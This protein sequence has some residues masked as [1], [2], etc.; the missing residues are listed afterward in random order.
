[1][2]EENVTRPVGDDPHEPSQL[3]KR[4][5]TGSLDQIDNRTSSHNMSQGLH[6]Q[7]VQNIDPQ[8][9][10]QL[11]GCLLAGLDDQE[12]SS[13]LSKPITNA[14][15]EGNWAYSATDLLAIRNIFGEQ[16]Y[17]AV[18]NSPKRMEEK[19]QKN[20]GEVIECVRMNFSRR[21]LED[22][23]IWLDVGFANGIAR[24]LFPEA[25]EG[26]T[27]LFNSHPPGS[28]RASDVMIPERLLGAT[29][30]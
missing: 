18:E 9:G 27:F 23:T 17:N 1:M 25:R 8:V 11:N 14:E 28:R 7:Q 6:E 16:I 30:E 4:Q 12:V 5:N 22:A 24:R 13:H 26:V 19:S 3:S 2:S 29:C 10:L 15:T 20:N 21:N